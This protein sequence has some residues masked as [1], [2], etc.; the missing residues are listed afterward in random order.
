MR[1]KYEL[2][3]N[4]RPAAP[5]SQPVS[6]A[7]PVL[8]QGEG[9][10]LR[11]LVP[12]ALFSSLCT[13]PWPFMFLTHS[14]FGSKNSVLS[15]HWASS[16]VTEPACCLL[17]YPLTGSRFPLAVGG[18]SPSLCLAPGLNDRQKH[19][20]VRLP[21]QLLVPTEVAVSFQFSMALSGL[22]CLLMQ[23]RQLEASTSETFSSISNTRFPSYMMIG[24]FMKDP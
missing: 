20:G 12:D 2:F 22:C 4:L 17:G 3:Y 5:P 19:L 16:C 10:L 11:S 1:A 24:G 6:Q 15:A 21:R 8:C 7:V 23:E 13:V 14:H 18:R 9:G